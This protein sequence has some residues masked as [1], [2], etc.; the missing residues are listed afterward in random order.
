MRK[1]RNEEEEE[2]WISSEE[3][4]VEDTSIIKLRV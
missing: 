1:E 2:D 4:R 3:P